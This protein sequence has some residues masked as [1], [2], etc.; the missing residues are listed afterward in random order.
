MVT[1]GTLYTI[2]PETNEVE[3]QPGRVRARNP[4][5]VVELI[6]SCY[7]TKNAV[8]YIEVRIDRSLGILAGYPAVYYK[9]AG[10]NETSLVESLPSEIE[11]ALSNIL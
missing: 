10:S 7:A 11:E 1:L 9:P 6:S 3:V 4:E 5:R 8:A 2:R